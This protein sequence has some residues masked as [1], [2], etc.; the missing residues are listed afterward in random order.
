M[1]R[2][3]KPQVESSCT[4]QD[5]KPRVY[6]NDGPWNTGPY[7]A[8]ELLPFETSVVIDGNRVRRANR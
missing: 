3:K 8:D 7:E 4:A 6:L 1:K 2:P 5:Q